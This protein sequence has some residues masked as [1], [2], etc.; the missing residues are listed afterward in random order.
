MDGIELVR[1]LR[2]D[3][4][5]R[6]RR[7]P[8]IML[9]GK[10]EKAD[11]ETARDSGITEFAIKPYTSH[12]L[13][14]RL[15]WL[16]EQ[17]RPFLLTPEYVGPDR[18]RRKEPVRGTDRR[19]RAPVPAHSSVRRKE[20]GRTSYVLLPEPTLKRRILL[21]D[22]LSSI[23]TPEVIEEAQA[24]LD[25]LRDASLVWL[26]HDMENLEKSYRRLLKRELVALK[27]F[28]DSSLAIKSRAAT[29]GYHG[30]TEAARLL[31]RF[32][33]S[34][35]QENT[36]ESDIILLT[37]IEAL[38]VMFSESITGRGTESGVSACW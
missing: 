24:A 14:E 30:M 1:A 26:R 33:C 9:T 27:A 3:E 38:K 36:A 31:Y 22:T 19:V 21:G 16:I 2:R 12:A 13:F 7:M 20:E 11:V 28:G 37:H 17:P 23:I 8:I 25:A 32:A 6:V 34:E 18:R 15:E 10:A 4:R 5:L 29:F 35:Y